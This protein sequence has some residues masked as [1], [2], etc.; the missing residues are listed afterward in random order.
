MLNVYRITQIIICVILR[1]AVFIQ[2]RSVTD[3][4]THT[5]T[6]KQYPLRW[7][8]SITKSIRWR[9]E[10]LA[11]RT[12]AAYISRAMTVDLWTCWIAVSFRP[13]DRSTRSCAVVVTSRWMC[14]ETEK[15]PAMLTPSTF[16]Q[17]LRV[18][19]GSGAGSGR[20]TLASTPAPTVS[21]D[22]LAGLRPTAIQP[23]IVP[24]HPCLNIRQFNLTG[25][26]VAG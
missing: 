22:H 1:L 14:W 10:V 4:H 23:Q 3:T 8:R 13:R 24:V 21:V 26:F 17:R 7:A 9:S 18:I 12:G 19:P 2:Y 5:H 20:P 6:N 25:G 15:L 11:P 16:R